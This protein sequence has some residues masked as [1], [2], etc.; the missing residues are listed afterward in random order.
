MK[1][2]NR[3]R[4]HGR[5]MPSLSKSLIQLDPAKYTRTIPSEGGSQFIPMPAPEPPIALQRSPVLLSALP[6]ISTYV[7]GVIRQF[8]GVSLPQ[9]R[10][11]IP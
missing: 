4:Y 10:I 6:P 8:Y 11:M 9:R 7:D 1:R 5:I 2:G 3:N